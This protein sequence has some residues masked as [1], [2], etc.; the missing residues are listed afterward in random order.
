[1]FDLAFQGSCQPKYFIFLDNKLSY[2][3]GGRQRYINENQRTQQI[4]TAC[5][6]SDLAQD[7]VASQVY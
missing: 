3:H 4:F 6:T 1:M 2:E 5:S 7:S